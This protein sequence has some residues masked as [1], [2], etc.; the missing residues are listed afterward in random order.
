MFLP[1]YLAGAAAIRSRRRISINSLISKVRQSLTPGCAH[2]VLVAFYCT[3]EVGTERQKL[4]HRPGGL[5]FTLI[6]VTR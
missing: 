2:S 1:W 3:P 6:P 4:S 5:R